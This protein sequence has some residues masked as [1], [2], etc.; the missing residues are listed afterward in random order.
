VRGLCIREKYLEIKKNAHELLYNILT[1]LSGESKSAGL[2]K[3]EDRGEGKFRISDKI[4]LS[5]DILDRLLTISSIL[6]LGA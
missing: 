5:C 1:F 2:K 4:T 6:I 3:E